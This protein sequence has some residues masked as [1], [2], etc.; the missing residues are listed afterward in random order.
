MAHNPALCYLAVSKLLIALPGCAFLLLGCIRLCA[1]REGHPLLFI[2]DGIAL[3]CGCLQGCAIPYFFYDGSSNDNTS[4]RMC[5][6]CLLRTSTKATH[7]TSPR[8]S[9]RGPCQ[10]VGAVTTGRLMQGAWQRWDGSNFNLSQSWCY[11]CSLSPDGLLDARLLIS[12]L[13]RGYISLWC[14]NHRGQAWP[15]WIVCLHHCLAYGWRRHV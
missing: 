10:A 14:L 15:G 12:R 1:I 11:Y 2:I 4:D 7:S 9:W 6:L 5:C 3:P 13:I 8:T